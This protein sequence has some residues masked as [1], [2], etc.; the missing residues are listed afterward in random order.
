MAFELAV[1]HA[2]V[3]PQCGAPAAAGPLI[4]VLDVTSSIAAAPAGIAA[5]PAGIAAAPAGIAAAPAGIAAAPAGIAAAPA[6]VATE[7]AVLVSGSDHFSLPAIPGW[8]SA[9]P[10]PWGT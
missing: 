8:I 5:A 9:T 1:S 2:F 10:L 3:P 4:G 7:A 6:G